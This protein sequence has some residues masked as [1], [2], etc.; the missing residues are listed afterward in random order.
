ML[1]VVCA[2]FAVLEL[3]KERRIT[4]FQNRLFG[5]IRITAR[6]TAAPEAAARGRRPR[7]RGPAG[8]GGDRHGT[9]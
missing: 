3:V 9:E 1:E 7:G 4:V 2:F 5:D 8:R 6:P